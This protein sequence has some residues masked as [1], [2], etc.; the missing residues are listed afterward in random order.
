MVKNASTLFLC[1]VMS[2]SVYADSLVIS[3]KVDRQEVEL[4]D[5]FVY[6][7]TLSGSDTGQIPNPILPQITGKCDIVSRGE[8][9]SII[10]QN[11]KSSRCV[12]TT[13]VM[14]PSK[15]G[16]L[17]LEPASVSY[18]GKTYR[19]EAL[20]LKVV[21][22]SGKPRR[23][24]PQ[25]GQGFDPFSGFFEPESPSQKD[26]QSTLFLQ[27]AANKNQAYVGEQIL[28]KLT[29][30]TRV[31]FYS[32]PTFESPVFEGCWSET[33]KKSDTPSHQTLAGQPYLAA[34]VLR[35]VLLP[36]KPGLLTI[37]TAKMGYVTNPFEGQRVLE[38][39]PFSIRILPLPEAGKPAHFSGGVG[40]FTLKTA[41]LSCSVCSQNA[42]LTLRI[43][44]E[45]SG[46]FK[47]LQDLYV[48]D[49]REFRLYKSKTTDHFSSMEGLSGQ[50]SFEYVL[51][52]KVSGKLSIPR[53]TF[54]YF[55]PRLKSYKTLST[56]AY[57]LTVT[58]V[59]S[60]VLADK[61]PAFSHA[62]EGIVLKVS[63][64]KT[65]LVLLGGLLGVSLLV[66]LEKK[67]LPYLQNR[68]YSIAYQK[69]TA[70]KTAMK[71]LVACE[72][73]LDQPH[74]LSA[75]QTIFITY[76]THSTGVTCKGLTQ[77]QIRS[78][79]SSNKV[80]N[81]AI[82]RALALFDRLSFAIYA[83]ASLR[84]DEKQSLLNEL[85]FVIKTLSLKKTFS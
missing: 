33:L 36:I 27:S 7:V 62:S 16:T 6:E 67:A 30:F 23:A 60:A 69:K 51:I 77:D 44:L 63:Y 83:P 13:Y 21:P 25:Q 39:K 26:T 37:S 10:I 29:L 49:T 73:E 58:P 34:E 4:H 80:P 64:L 76:L 22:D 41:P 19:T 79:L 24:P 43:T 65:T 74:S 59:S 15:T 2:I 68:I 14:A 82:T 66:L 54:S 53:F 20:T 11:G 57:T 78:V 42:P 85:V 8:S 1:M 35:K 31:H 70:F 61:A 55:S 81:E 46:N 52:P 84:I 3:A 32:N 48:P 9:T 56:E 17:T 72:A 28:Y 5:Q 18:K 38:S 40:D 75:L 12:T 71:A 45:G 47:T 50:R